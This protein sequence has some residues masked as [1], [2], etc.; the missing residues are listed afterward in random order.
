MLPFKIS[1]LI[2]VRNSEGELLLIER[3]KDP[4]RGCWSPIGGKLEMITG[5]SPYETAMRE[6]REEAGLELTEEDLHLF[7]MISEKGYE[8]KTHWLMFLFDCLKPIQQLPPA[9]EEG[10][11]A[12]C[13]ESDLPGLP[14]P[15]TDRDFLWPIYL[16]DHQ[17]FSVL[18]AD[19]FKGL[20][21]NVIVEQRMPN[22]GI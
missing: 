22:S 19:C 5:E 12:F 1:V 15:E 7:C 9:I 17:G 4:N 10:R 13:E 11:F 6:A 3:N 2:F 8:G 21:E 14:V 16:K 18:R 20:P